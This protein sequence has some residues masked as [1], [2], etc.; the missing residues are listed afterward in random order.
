M[1]TKQQTEIM[2]QIHRLMASHPDKAL[3]EQTH[4]LIM[5]NREYRSAYAGAAWELMDSG[6]MQKLRGT[7]D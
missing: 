3:V 7:D 1:I 2:K 4:Q 5:K 6:E